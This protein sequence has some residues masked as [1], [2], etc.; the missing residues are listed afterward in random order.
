MDAGFLD[1]LQNQI[2]SV[3]VYFW[4]LID[5]Q[6]REAKLAKYV[7]QY[8]QNEKAYADWKIKVFFIVMLDDRL[9]VNENQDLKR[10]GVFANLVREQTMNDTHFVFGFDNM[11]AILLERG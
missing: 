7:S 1:Q 2:P 4:K 10:E 5:K 11:V 3:V 8:K 9:V 6:T